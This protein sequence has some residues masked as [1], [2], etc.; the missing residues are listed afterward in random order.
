MIRHALTVSELRIFDAEDPAPMAEYDAS[1]L[2]VWETP[3][4]IWLRM[5]RGGLSRKMLRS[6]LTWL[7]EQRIEVV[8]AHRAHGHVLPLARVQPDGSFAVAVPELAGRFL[9]PEATSDWTPL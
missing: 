9:R 3:S 5:L 6:L 1:C 4:V 7:V 8:K 2:V